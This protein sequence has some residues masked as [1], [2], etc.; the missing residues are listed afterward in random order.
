[1]VRR[2]SLWIM[3]YILKLS[4]LKK[5]KAKRRRR[6]LKI[7]CLT[8]P[9]CLDQ[10]PSRINLFKEMQAKNIGK[11]LKTMLQRSASS[12]KK[13]KS[14]FLVFQSGIRPLK[15]LKIWGWRASQWWVRIAKTFRYSSNNLPKIRKGFSYRWKLGKS[16]WFKVFKIDVRN[17][18][19][20]SR[21]NRRLASWKSC[22]F[23]VLLPL[24]SC[25]IRATKILPICV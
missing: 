10:K 3:S 16:P 4:R 25:W 22:S 9:L 17:S 20:T 5:E 15:N 8:S 11:G 24:T 18:K 12:T 23:T 21:S 6:R 13:T 2:T 14:S 19:K 7:L 1:M